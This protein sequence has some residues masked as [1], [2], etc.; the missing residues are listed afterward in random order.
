MTSVCGFLGKR[1]IPCPPAFLI[2]KSSIELWYGE[3][4][5]LK[6]FSFIFLETWKIV[7]VWTSEKDL[8]SCSAFGSPHSSCALIND[9]VTALTS[10]EQTRPLFLPEQHPGKE[11]LWVSPPQGQIL[12][13][14]MN[15]V[16]SWS[17][18]SM[19]LIL[20]VLKGRQ[21]SE[22]AQAQTGDS[23]WNIIFKMSSSL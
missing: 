13:S 23:R 18:K 4:L 7:Y 14:L 10:A 3:K 17:T 6:N 12:F 2:R 11:V 19:A 5:R 8:F 1:S 16:R 22:G 15:C 9:E 20:L 21:F